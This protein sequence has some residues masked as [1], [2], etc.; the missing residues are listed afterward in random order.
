[1]L[2]DRVVR[3][4]TQTNPEAE[5]EADRQTDRTGM[6]TEKHLPHTEQYITFV[7]GRR[8]GW[9]GGARMAAGK[10]AVDGGQRVT[11]QEEHR[12]RQG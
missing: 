2:H 9:M 8:A 11:E 3:A 10:D 5:A 6:R 7:K 4:S 1:M 12:L